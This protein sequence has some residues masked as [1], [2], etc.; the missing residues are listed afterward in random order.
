MSALGKAGVVAVVTLSSVYVY[1]ALRGPQGIPA[2][3][4]K[5]QEI[6]A[7][8][9]RNADL[10]REVQM[11][12]ERIRRLKESP[13][14]QELEIRKRLKLLRPGET[15]FIIPETPASEEPVQK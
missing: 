2:L 9:Q 3:Q 13:A 15:T 5:W 4:E 6:R 1:M 10:S 14:E 7:M 12:N 8:Q 11:R